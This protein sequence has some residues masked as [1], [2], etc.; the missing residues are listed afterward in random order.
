MNGVVSR[1][2]IVPQAARQL[3]GA[4]AWSLVAIAPRAAAAQVAVLPDDSIRAILKDRVDSHRS[5]GIVVGVLDAVGGRHVIGYGPTADGKGTLDGNSVFEIGSVTKTFTASILSDM[6]ARGE[7]SLT[8]P[9]AKFLPPDVKV[10]SRD[11]K[12]I[13]LLDLTTQSSGLPRMPTNFSPKDINNPYADYTVRQMY[14]FLSTYTLPRD[15]GAQ[16]EYSNLGVGLLGHALARRAGTD[17]ETLVTNRITKPLGMSDTRITLS[18]SMRARLATGHD[19]QGT[20][21]ANWDLPTLAGAGAI[22]STVNDMLRFVAANLD[23]ASVPLGNTLAAAHLPL[24]PTASGNTRIGMNWHITDV[25]GHSIVWHNGQTAGYHTFVGLDE[26]RHIGVVVLA[27][28]AA[29][30][31]DIGFHLL[32]PAAP[33]APAPAPMKVRSEIAVDP[34]T[35]DTYVGVYVFGPTV[36]LTITRDGAQMFAQ[37]TG[38]ERLPIYAESRTDF[39]L[40]VVDAQ[41]TFEKDTSGKVSAVVL[42]QN[43][44]NQ[45]AA[46]Q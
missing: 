4:L 23:S 6:V 19:Q 27:N 12:E 22:R 44:A 43:G 45:R 31:D 24:R 11:G 36:T 42:H 39:F 14:D 3:A 33:L 15:P 41:L 46:K 7:V 26:Q 29:N 1:M 20:A 18:R 16:Y 9:V 32:V 10:P 28:S 25:L 38:Q 17:Y 40:K 35:L 34:A 37:L 13:T 5:T 30:I 21:V 8:D 2:R